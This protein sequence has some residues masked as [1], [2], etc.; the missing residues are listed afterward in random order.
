[1][2]VPLAHTLIFPAGEGWIGGLPQ[3][4]LG[5]RGAW[6]ALMIYVILLG[7]G[8]YWRWRHAAWRRMSL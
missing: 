1:V 6:L 3:Y 7:L 4:G 5:A 2:Y 8:M